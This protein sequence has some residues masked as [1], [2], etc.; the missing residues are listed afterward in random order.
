MHREWGG[1]CVVVEGPA[2]FYERAK[3]DFLKSLIFDARPTD[4]AAEFYY[5]TLSA[6]R[7]NVP[8]KKHDDHVASLLADRVLRNEDY[9]T[10][11]GARGRVWHAGDRRRVVIA[12]G[13]RREVAGGAAKQGGVGG[14]GFWS[15]GHTAPRRP[16]V[17]LK[18]VL[19]R[20]DWEHPTADK[21]ALARKA[22]SARPERGSMEDSE[23]GVASS[24]LARYHP[25][26]RLN[27]FRDSV[28][29]SFPGL[30]K[31]HMFLYSNGAQ[32][33]H[34]IDKE[35]DDW[36]QQ[37][38]DNG[39]N[40]IIGRWAIPEH[41]EGAS[42]GGLYNRGFNAWRKR[43][44][45][46]FGREPSE[47]E[48]HRQY[49]HHLMMRNEGVAH[50]DLFNT[51]YQENGESNLNADTM[52]QALSKA[53]A[54]DQLG[55]L[56]HIWGLDTL[57]PEERAEIF[58][59]IADKPRDENIPHLGQ[60]GKGFI[61]RVARHRLGAMQQHMTN[62][63]GKVGTQL[64]PNYIGE[65]PDKS[66]LAAE[67]VPHESW[68]N[69]LHLMKNEDG[70]NLRDQLINSVAASEK[71]NP[72]DGNF[73]VYSGKR[74]TVKHNQR[75]DLNAELL[76]SLKTHG[77]MT[78]EQH[79]Q[80]VALAGQL[81]SNRARHNTIHDAL[82][83]HD[84]PLMPLRDW[85]M[86]KDSVPIDAPKSFAHYA[87]SLFDDEGGQARDST[88]LLYDMHE[89]FPGIFT[90]FKDQVLLGGM[91][92]IP[93]VYREAN[94]P[95]MGQRRQKQ[96][97]HDVFDEGE[98]PEGEVLSYPPFGREGKTPRTD[99]QQKELGG[100]SRSLYGEE[101][102]AETAREHAWSD[103][104]DIDLRL[105]DGLQWLFDCIAPTYYQREEGGISSLNRS[106]RIGAHID[107]PVPG[108]TL[109]R[110][111]ARNVRDQNDGHQHTGM[112]HE[113]G[114]GG[115]ETSYGTKNSHRPS[116]DLLNQYQQHMMLIAHLCGWHHSLEDDYTGDNLRALW[117]N[118]EILLNDDNAAEHTYDM[119]GRGKLRA[120]H[121]DEL[122]LADIDPAEKPFAVYDFNS[123]RDMVSAGG[124]ID[125]RGALIPNGEVSSG[126]ELGKLLWNLTTH[127]LGNLDYDT[128]MSRAVEHGNSR[129]IQQLHQAMTDLIPKADRA[130]QKRDTFN[131]HRSKDQ[132]S[133]EDRGIGDSWLH[134]MS[135]VRLHN[136]SN[137]NETQY[138]VG[139]PPEDLTET[140]ADRIRNDLNTARGDVHEGAAG[141][142]EQLRERLEQQEQ[143]HHH[144]LAGRFDEGSQSSVRDISNE[145]MKA[146]L[147]QINDSRKAAI[148]MGKAIMAYVQHNTNKRDEETGDLLTPEMHGLF[149]AD[150]N[151]NRAF[152]NT[153]MAL[154]GGM[155]LALSMSKS[156]RAQWAQGL[157]Q[158]GIIDESLAGEISNLQTSTRPHSELRL[159]EAGISGLDEWFEQQT[160]PTGADLL[161]AY[162]TG[163]IG[164]SENASMQHPIA[165]I[166]DAVKEAAGEEG[167]PALHFMS[168]YLPQSTH[169]VSP[170]SGQLIPHT[171]QVG[172]RTVRDP[173]DIGPQAHNSIGSKGIR[174]NQTDV[175]A[176]PST[177]DIKGKRHALLH[178][179]ESVGANMLTELSGFQSILNKLNESMA[180]H[181][182]SLGMSGTGSGAG[183]KRGAE[184]IGDPAQ[185][186]RK[187]QKINLVKKMVNTLF[188]PVKKRVSTRHLQHSNR[189]MDVDSFNNLQRGTL[190]DIF[191]GAMGR[192]MGS[193]C[194]PD[195]DVDHHPIERTPIMVNRQKSPFSGGI[196]PVNIPLSIPLLQ[197]L[198]PNLQGFDA[199]ANIQDRYIDMESSGGFL[200]GE[201]RNLAIPASE[202]HEITGYDTQN[203]IMNLSA[204]A[205]LTGAD[206][207]LKEDEER[208][209][210][211][212]PPIKAM[213][214]IFNLEDLTHLRGFTGDWLVTSWPK[215][216]TR[217][218]VK[219]VGDK[220]T[221]YDSEGHGIGLPRSVIQG[222]KEA[223]SVDF[224]IDGLWDGKRLQVVDM[225]KVAEDE[226]QHDHLKD[227][228]RHLRANFES[229]D[230][231]AMPAP[232]NTRRADD[233]GL[234]AAVQ[235]LLEEPD[236]EQIMLRDAESTYMLGERRHPKWVLYT[237]SKEVDV[238]ILGRRKGT[239]RLGVGPIDSS[240]ANKIGNR[241][242]EYGGQSYMEVG[243]VES[244]ERYSVGDHITV[245][246]SGVTHQTRE[247]EDVFTL[248]T[249]SVL[250]ESETEAANGVETLCVLACNEQ[251][252]VPH[253]VKIEKSR[254]RVSF[255]A[256]G[257]DVIYKVERWGD[258][259]G[260]TDPY[261]TD[262]TDGDYFIHLAES[263]RPYWS[264]I[265]A[266]MLKGHI[267][268]T[269]EEDKAHVEVEPLANHKKKPKKVDEDQFFKD[270]VVSKS[271]IAALQIIERVMKEKLTWTGPKG[272]GFDYATGD[273]ESPRGPTELTRPSTLPDFAP[274][275][276][277][278]EE[279]NKDV[280][281]N[282]N[283]KRKTQKITTEQGEKA[284]LDI[285]EDTATLIVPNDSLDIS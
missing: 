189:D 229:T 64:P 51:L 58:Q 266:L 171:K 145:R 28:G 89:M 41:D 243:T 178:G 261:T 240:H 150:T 259:W 170:Q 92:N 37:H 111:K 118:P 210:G 113:Q 246:V 254:L 211:T 177:L 120:A 184:L 6:L 68:L 3:T 183:G 54:E 209:K 47:E 25:L 30:A 136:A 151:H 208:D 22:M 1:G 84:S 265:V 138:V 52:R 5:A 2:E 126:E 239:Y 160:E 206:D 105:N 282:E 4:E 27:L 212:P 35:M 245:E 124:T 91:P 278:P 176:F 236:V 242:A 46:R 204:L 218:I 56:G 103:I 180:G 100:Y 133:R 79:E 257:E 200:P 227:R 16:S 12:P 221:H 271:V 215:N 238:I 114:S 233:E 29:R 268:D 23:S 275:E 109:L 154:K 155:R 61:A 40:S 162:A 158:D 222:V 34:Q 149:D 14:S 39:H 60:H 107:T 161:R 226:S 32:N 106:S 53:K 43:Y 65:I 235:E 201:G 220:V 179:G 249:L 214:R 202:Y 42:Y 244:K 147:H 38:L 63:P 24:L 241:G 129:I 31:Q 284:V 119:F 8:L 117:N 232:I 260:L 62:G 251:E 252:N 199:D 228:V 277:D 11:A 123:L 74:H 45:D 55:L 116:T 281:E 93:D 10:P 85:D 159:P 72:S 194:Y 168:R 193:L 77:H 112:G 224:I 267:D 253:T 33:A 44:R 225:L 187:N 48:A 115:D 144:I 49:D 80:L 21:T 131:I 94:E 87:H 223:A 82:G 73:P 262:F 175:G 164:D 231:V 285:E 270:P 76:H 181:G 274:A 174:W 17:P 152:V 99:E 258:A 169:F 186:T 101:V 75:V 276:R 13:E 165:R 96:A 148:T 156:E 207:L 69:A 185:A 197:Q 135:D 273:V 90:S 141:L 195:F 198:N 67:R 182:L 205:H 283:K 66:A 20:I 88:S 173:Q 125:P 108:T 264:P 280:L 50:D 250:G 7:S 190:K 19:H 83:P 248:Q 256:L 234:E 153:A 142:R 279:E 122:G 78:D 9:V 57:E 191:G 130:G 98:P 230:A 26:E 86:M 237:P 104:G 216:A 143:I 70:L 36:E 263:Q 163:E 167:D 15:S 203:G 18:E 192:Y 146:Q 137:D 139:P 81:A 272:F 140:W 188:S 255:P 59:H 71:A 95:I 132:M 134:R 166:L 97:V 219:K 110:N 172:K 217:V 269:E 213:H 121:L 157:L 128:T 102:P 196:K 247:G 127:Q